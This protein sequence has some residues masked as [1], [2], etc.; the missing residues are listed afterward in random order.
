MSKKDAGATDA[1]VPMPEKKK[2]RLIIL[3]VIAAVIVVVGIAGWK[4]HEQ[5]SFCNAICHQPMDR[6]VQEYYNPDSELLI[7][8]HGKQ[9]KGI[10]CLECHVPTISQQLTE[11]EHWVTGN[12]TDPLA[13][14]NLGNEF[15]L[16]S[17][18]HP[19]TYEELEQA[20]KDLPWNPHSR[21]HGEK[22]C[23]SCHRM[24]DVSVLNCAGCHEQA[25]KIL[26]KG[27]ITP[28]QAKEQGL[29]VIAS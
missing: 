24:H 26:P 19:F 25:N 4:W 16:Q 29:D 2:K 28:Q 6:Y 15:C 10:T 13:K 18:C 3:G 20:T 14:R 21:H 23:A 11:A 22:Q 27:W 12:F 7:A 9:G 8:K 17:K 1:K 5:P